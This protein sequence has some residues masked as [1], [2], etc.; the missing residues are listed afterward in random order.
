DRWLA[1]RRA[2]AAKYLETI[3]ALAPGPSGSSWHLFPAIAP[4]KPRFIEH[5]T[6]AGI[7]TGEHY[8]TLIPDQK[9]LDR[10]PHEVIGDLTNAL[11]ITRSEVSLPIHPY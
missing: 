11:A 5:M 6:A 10:V 9:A 8:P 7:G 3:I 1:R 4:D 2:I